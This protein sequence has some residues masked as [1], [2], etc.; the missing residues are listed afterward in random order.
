[1]PAYIVFPDRS[2]VDM[3]RKAPR[4]IEAF[5]AVNGVGAAKLRDFAAPFLA[6]IAAVTEGTE[7]APVTDSVSRQDPSG[8]AAPG[9]GGSA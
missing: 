8:P 1:V 4:T 2:L 5:A 9:T 6:A 7:A 3:A